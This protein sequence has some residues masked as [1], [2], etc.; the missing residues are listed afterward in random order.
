MLAARW[1]WMIRRRPFPSTW[2]VG[3]GRPSSPEED[4]GSPPRAAQPASHADSA[5]TVR[6][7][8]F[9]RPSRGLPSYLTREF[10][11]ITAMTNVGKIAS[12]RRRR[13]PPIWGRLADPLQEC[14]SFRPALRVPDGEVVVVGHRLFSSSST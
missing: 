7:C 3:G 1:S 10:P 12:G 5:M 4:A 8:L 14:P 6:T 13:D 9:T 11:H 2:R